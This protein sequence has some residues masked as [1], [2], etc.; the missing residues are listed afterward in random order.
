MEHKIG[1]IVTLPDGRKAKVVEGKCE[2]ELCA[3]WDKIEC[4]DKCCY[5]N[6]R[7]DRKHII[8][9]EIKEK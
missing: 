5:P 6:D 4:I 2:D 9:R 3:L 7:T 1:K 8:Y